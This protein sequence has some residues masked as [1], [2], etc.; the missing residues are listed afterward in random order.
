MASTSKLRQSDSDALGSAQGLGLTH[1][2]AL[3]AIQS[4]PASRTAAALLAS[5]HSIVEEFQARTRARGVSQRCASLVRVT[6]CIE[7][8]AA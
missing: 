2:A 7:G 6:D 4:F 8:G 5:S 1:A 3:A